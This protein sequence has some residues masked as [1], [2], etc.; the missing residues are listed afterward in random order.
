M[1]TVVVTAH[2]RLDAATASRLDDT[3]SDL[4]D[5]Q[6]NLT[7]DLDLYDADAVEFASLVVLVAWNAAVAGRGGVLSFADPNRSVID[8]LEDAGLG[9]AI[10]LTRSRT[11]RSVPAA[12]RDRD[13]DE[14]RRTSMADHPAR[15]A[16]FD[17]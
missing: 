8:A 13:P 9:A 15:L 17:R 14:R 5:G 4:I 16:G 7:L 6:G 2:G 1:G 11:L 10:I 3:L 12:G